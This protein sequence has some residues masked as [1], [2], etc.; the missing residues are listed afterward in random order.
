MVAVLQITIFIINSGHG[1]HRVKTKECRTG[2]GC[3]VEMLP[4]KPFIATEKKQ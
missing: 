4:M 2:L 1:N 3:R